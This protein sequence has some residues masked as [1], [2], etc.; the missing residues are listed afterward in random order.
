MLWACV[1]L[2]SLALD[3][4][5][6]GRPAP[7]QPFVLA[8][9]PAQQRRIVA[10]DTHARAAGLAPGQRLAEAEAIC[11]NLVAVEYE[12]RATHAS[13]QLIAAWAYRYSS[14]VL[15]DPP[16]AV[17]LEVG[18]SLGLFGPWPELERRL[19]GELAQLGYTHRIALAPNPRAA[20]VLAGVADGT[21]V[22]SAEALPQALARIAVAR[23]GLPCAAVD[24]LAGMGIRQLGALLALPR[25]AL[26]RRFGKPLVEALAVLLGERPAVLASYQPAEVFHERIDL[27]CEVRHHQALLFPLRR[28]LGDLATVLSA[29]DGGV[30]RFTIA[31]DHADHSATTLEVGLLAPERG[32]DALFEVARLRLEQCRLP[33]AVLELSV[34]AE[35]LP[36]FTPEARDLLDPRAASALPLPQLIER[37][38]ARLGDDAVHGLHADPDPRPERACVRDIADGAIASAALPARPAWLLARPIPLRGPAPKI[39]AGP[40]RLETGW[41][42]GDDIRRDY[43]VL[44]LTGGQRAW[45]FAAAGERGPYMLHGWFA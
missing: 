43:Y 22:E 31:F 19:R 26:Q 7:T 29:R 4:A 1:L 44:E 32:A 35:A 40:E 14:Q 24:A 8:T 34:H 28:L 3:A 37:L 23:A 45:A 27:G 15:S 5:L 13:L 20:K 6:R 11:R 39:L 33:Q 30:Q 16:R 36:P 42:D 21:V 18:K 9:G 10:V 41:W 17:I 12:P 25:A 38:R 2:P